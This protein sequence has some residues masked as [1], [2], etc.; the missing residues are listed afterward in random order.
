MKKV[1]GYVIS[2][3][4]ILIMA[5][6]LEIVSLDWEIL[7]LVS[8]GYVVGLGV[9]LIVVGVF[10]SLSREVKGGKVKGGENEVPIF[11][12]VGKSRRIV[13]YRDR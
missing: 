5:V 8:S 12:G 2:I 6:G 3:F 7:N 4:G 13:G 9:V 11:E 1:I 10:I